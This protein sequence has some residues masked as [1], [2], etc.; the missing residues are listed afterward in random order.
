M[1]KGNG[2][3]CFIFYPP[4]VKII[5]VSI[6]KILPIIFLQNIKYISIFNNYKNMEQI[7]LD[8]FDRKIL[9]EIDKKSNIGLPE[10]SHKLR[11][12]K[13]FI[14]YRLKRLE[15]IGIITGYHAIIDMSKLGYFTFRVYFKFQQMSKKDGN[16]FVHY[17]ENSLDQVWTITSMH[18]KWDFAL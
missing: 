14:L 11:R 2:L 18:G 16:E 4:I 8:L 5:C 12:S 6:Y 9:Y 15:D 10:L 17:V 3:S 7:K 13:Q 1:E